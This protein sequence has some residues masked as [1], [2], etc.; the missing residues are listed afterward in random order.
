MQ[1]L[2]HFPFNEV[3]FHFLQKKTRPAYRKSTAGSDNFLHGL[4]VA[5]Y[6]PFFWGE[7][8]RKLALTFKPSL[9]INH[10]F[11]TKLTV[12][13]QFTVPT[14]VT[15]EKSIWFISS[16]ANFNIGVSNCCLPVCWFWWKAVLNKSTVW[17]EISS[18]YVRT[19]YIQWNH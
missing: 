18:G 6:V 11:H 14:M 19:H 3:M 16:D 13:T 10:L 7:L 9:Y 17:C 4:K 15:K 8:Q 5:Q 1:H 12:Q 2:P